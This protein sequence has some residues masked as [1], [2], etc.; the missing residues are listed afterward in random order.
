MGKTWDKMILQWPCLCY[1]TYSG[2]PYLYLL[3]LYYLNGSC[4][5]LRGLLFLAVVICQGMDMGHK[6]GQEECFSKFPLY[7]AFGENSLKS[8]QN[9]ESAQTCKSSYS[10]KPPY[11]L[12]P[13]LEECILSALPSP[14]SLRVSY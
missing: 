12:I 13:H 7:G 6:M 3:W 2:E 4:H 11:L 10:L 5:I 1:S 9:R 8:E 14:N